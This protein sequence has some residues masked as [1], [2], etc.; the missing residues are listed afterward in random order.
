[1][2]LAELPDAMPV[3]AAGIIDS[4]DALTLRKATD[5]FCGDYRQDCGMRR[6]RP[7][8]AGRRSGHSVQAR[9]APQ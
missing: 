9:S 1:V 7:Q 8:G 6:G 5:D 3:R 4:G 2:E